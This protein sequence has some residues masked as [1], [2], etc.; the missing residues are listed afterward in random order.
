M[1]PYK[2]VME[3]LV[4]EEVVRQV[5]A[6]PVRIA[7]YINQTELVAYALNQLPPLYATS[8][9]GLEHQLE[10]GKVK[11]A[12]Q[13]S[14]AVQRS[15]AAIRRDPLRT[16]VPLKENQATPFREVLKQMQN[17]L[18][19]D[20]VDWANLPI[21]VEQALHRASQGEMS[22]DKRYVGRSP[23]TFPMAN[24]PLPSKARV[25]TDRLSN[26]SSHQPQTAQQ[27]YEAEFGWDDPLYNPRLSKE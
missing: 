9:K 24:L 4:E 21:A 23:Q 7:S 11:F 2:N 1:A 27:N 17:L 25:E 26:P 22:W 13:I 18:Q 15:I 20:Q 6:L 10:R 19:N 3:F 5:K 16:Y 12:A 14:Q 8:E